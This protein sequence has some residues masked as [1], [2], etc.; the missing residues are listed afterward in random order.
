MSKVIKGH[1]AKRYKKRRYPTQEQA[2]YILDMREARRLR[3]IFTE[4]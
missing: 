2:K 3:R 1:N 4:E